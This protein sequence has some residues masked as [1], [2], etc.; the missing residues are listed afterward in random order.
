MRE[1]PEWKELIGRALADRAD[2]W[3][4]VHLPSPPDA[5]E[6]TCAF[7][8]SVLSSQAPLRR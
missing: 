7:I 4:R 2:P 1:L 6:R 8:D 3:E 5:D